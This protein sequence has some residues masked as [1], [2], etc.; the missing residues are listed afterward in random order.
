MR[1]ATV[2]LGD[3]P[4]QCWLCPASEADNVPVADVDIPAGSYVVVAY[5]CRD[6]EAYR[7]DEAVKR[8][9]AER[10]VS[11]AVPRRGGCRVCGSPSSCDCQRHDPLG[12]VEPPRERRV[13]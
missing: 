6:C 13:A 12:L 7:W 4:R 8:A 3:Y 5:L 1:D 2:D 10:G 9:E 11:V